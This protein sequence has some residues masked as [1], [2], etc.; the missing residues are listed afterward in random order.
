[1]ALE[2]ENCQKKICLNTEAALVESKLEFQL[3]KRKSKLDNPETS[4]FELLHPKKR[5]KAFGSMMIDENM[6]N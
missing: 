4:I 2:W 1:M 6:I 3:K 5:L